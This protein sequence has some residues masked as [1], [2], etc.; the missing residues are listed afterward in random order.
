MIELCYVLL[1]ET[2]DSVIR[3]GVRSLDGIS[4]PVGLIRVW[5]CD[6]GEFVTVFSKNIEMQMHLASFNITNI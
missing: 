1:T 4:N 3:D 2:M 5:N 6:T